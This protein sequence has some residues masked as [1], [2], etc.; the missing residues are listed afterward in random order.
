MYSK[1]IMTIICIIS[2]ITTTINIVNNAMNV[3]CQKRKMRRPRL[4]KWE[5]M[6]TL[7]IKSRESELRHHKCV[8]EDAL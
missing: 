8:A 7:H 6:T 5:E 2:I 4:Y 1:F 3:M